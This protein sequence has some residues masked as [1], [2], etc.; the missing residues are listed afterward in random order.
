MKNK[1]DS[2]NKQ[3]QYFLE[4]RKKTLSQFKEILKKVNIQKK[5]C[6]YIL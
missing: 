3:F 2:K 6:K 5:E 1:K 4:D